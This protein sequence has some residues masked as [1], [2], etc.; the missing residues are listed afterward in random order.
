MALRDLSEVSTGSD[1][2]VWQIQ[3][4]SDFQRFLEQRCGDDDFV[5]FRGQREDWD[6]V[7]KLER[8]TRRTSFAEDVCL[9][10]T[11]STP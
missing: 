1:Y 10:K 5:L 2:P 7:P 11:S 6:L 3:K 9:P 8:L 4:L